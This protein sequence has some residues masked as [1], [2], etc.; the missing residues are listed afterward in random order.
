VSVPA[1][2]G[3]RLI[4]PFPADLAQVSDGLVAIT[5]SGVTSLTV[6]AITL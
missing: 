3:E 6:A 4:G 1:T 5:Y 2:T